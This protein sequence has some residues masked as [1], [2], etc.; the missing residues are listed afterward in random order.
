MP[1]Y[2][3]NAVD[4]VPFV[5]YSPQ[6]EK[7]IRLYLEACSCRFSFFLP[8]HL[9]HN[10]TTMALFYSLLALAATGGAL[11]QGPVRTSPMGFGGVPNA[12]APVGRP[13]RGA[14]QSAGSPQY[15]MYSAPLP[16]SP[17]AVPE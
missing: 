12:K 11:A 5:V 13:W 4:L 3:F 16:R 6:R 10:T 15:P 7:S 9:L 14:G 2:P 1:T 17:L 8:L